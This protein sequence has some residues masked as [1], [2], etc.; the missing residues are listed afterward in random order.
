MVYGGMYQQIGENIRTTF[1]YL[2]VKLVI[3]FEKHM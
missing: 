2:N 3:L 1:I